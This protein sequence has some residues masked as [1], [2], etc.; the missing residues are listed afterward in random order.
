MAQRGS[1]SGTGRRVGP[2]ACAAPD[3]LVDEPLERAVI[4]AIASAA[5]GKRLV[6]VK[7]GQSVDLEQGDGGRVAGVA[8]DEI[9]A[10]EVA[11]AERL[12]RGA[13]A[14]DW[15]RRVSSGPSGAGQSVD[16]AAGRST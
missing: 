1:G 12:V 14:S 9:D 5:S 16:A 2:R 3:E 7:P 10:G 6:A 13:E 4:P 11:A 8:D 15:T